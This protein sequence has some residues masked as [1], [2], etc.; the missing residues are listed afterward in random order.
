MT[1]R[2]IGAVKASAY[3][4]DPDGRKIG[5][6]ELPW[7]D[8]RYDNTGFAAGEEHALLLAVQK[9]G[10][11]GFFSTPGTSSFSSKTLATTLMSVVVTLRHGNGLESEE[12]KFSLSNSPYLKL[13]LIS[14]S[15]FP[16]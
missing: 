5:V 1:E 10:T 12:L 16:E 8:E 9:E 15:K 2:Q 4:Y 14:A 7:L 6:T 11:T 13:S 3:F